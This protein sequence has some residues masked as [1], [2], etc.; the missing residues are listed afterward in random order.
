MLTPAICYLSTAVIQAVGGPSKCQWVTHAHL[1]GCRSKHARPGESEWEAQTGNQSGQRKNE[2][3][4]YELNHF[5][6]VTLL[7]KMLG[8][9]M[10]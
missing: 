2:N 8:T 6:S 5:L 3:V 1:W 7:I 10:S 9:R 4:S